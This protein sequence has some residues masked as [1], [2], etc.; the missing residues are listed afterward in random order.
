MQVRTVLSVY[1]FPTLETLIYSSSV[2]SR[3]L[4]VSVEL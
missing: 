4:V 2:C 3:F 1:H